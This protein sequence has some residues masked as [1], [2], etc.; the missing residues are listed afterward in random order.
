MGQKVS[1]LAHQPEVAKR[2]R[3]VRAVGE[4]LNESA[5][6][7]ARQRAQ[8]GIPL[9]MVEETKRA[10]IPTQDATADATQTT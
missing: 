4:L 6:G 5:V 3:A 7:I 8:A 1:R 2:A 10:D 9:L